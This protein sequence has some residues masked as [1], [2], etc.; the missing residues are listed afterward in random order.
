MTTSDR[1][2]FEVTAEWVNIAHHEQVTSRE[3]YGFEVTGVVSLQGVRFLPKGQS[4]KT[5]VIYMHPTADMTQLP[6]PREMARHGLHVLCASS[7]YA[8]NDSCLIMEKVVSDYGG[9][10]RHAKEVWGYEKLVLVGWSGGGSLTAMYQAQAERP[11]IVDTPAGDPIHLS[12]MEA[13]DAIIFHSAHLSRAECLQD[14]IDPS[15]LDESNPDIRDR[16]LDLYDKRNPNQPPYSTDF[17]EYYRAAQR[18]RI[19]RRTNYVKELLD[20]YRST[21]AAT[22]DH[23]IVTHRTLAEPRYLDGNIDPNDRE[24]GTCFMGDPR[25]ANLNPSGL[26]RFSTL[27]AWLSQ[28]SVDDTRAHA[29]RAAASITVPVLSME[30]SADDCV[31]QPHIGRFHAAA[32]SKD[33]SYHL[34]VGGTH[35]YAGQPDKLREAVEFQLDWLERRQ[36]V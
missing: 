18:A 5:L 8:R 14:F 15:I 24:I 13:G 27:R 23:A 10:V 7:R 9:Y 20:Q 22:Y 3:V 1:P 33:K 31:P 6:V 17:I 12:K 21:G 30:N 2:T 19:V 29:E 26:A 36:L 25:E 4:S 35:Y 16:E 11:T 28:W 34:I 32:A